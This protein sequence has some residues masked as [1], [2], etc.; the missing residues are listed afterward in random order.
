MFVSCLLVLLVHISFQRS[1]DG[2]FALAFFD[3]ASFVVLFFSFCHTDFQFN[4]WSLSIDGKGDYCQ[5]IFLRFSPY[6]VNLFLVQKN[7]SASVW[8]VCWDGRVGIFGYARVGQHGRSFV[9]SDER[10]FE[11]DLSIAY[12]FHLR[13]SQCQTSLERIEDF[14]VMVGFSIFAICRHRNMARRI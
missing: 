8:L 1:A 12:R 14:K 11:I 9:K 2:A 3:G 4:Q 6:V 13:A 5:A 10:A 7:S